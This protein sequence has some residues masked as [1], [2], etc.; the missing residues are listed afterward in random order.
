MAGLC[1][2]TASL[3]VSDEQIR[4][5]VKGQIAKNPKLAHFTK[6]QHPASLFTNDESALAEP[7]PRLAVSSTH[8]AR[9]CS[10][11]QIELIKA[12]A[13]QGLAL[14]SPPLVPRP[15]RLFELPARLALDDGQSLVDRLGQE[16]R[17]R[18]PS[19]PSRVQSLNDKLNSLGKPLTDL[20]GRNVRLLMLVVTSERVGT[21]LS[22]SSGQSSSAPPHPLWSSDLPAPESGSDRF[23]RIG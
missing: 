21:L 17:L 6:D 10:L 7:T 13:S 23:E 4:T 19:S 12:Q 22:S 9:A 2:D 3:I 16:G 14:M 5:T 8:T 20:M 15:A 11:F 18:V 1:S